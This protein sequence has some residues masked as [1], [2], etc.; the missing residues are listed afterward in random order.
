MPTLVCRLKGATQSWGIDGK[1]GIRDTENEPSKSGFFSLIGCAMGKGRNEFDYFADLRKCKMGV[2]I[3]LPGTKFVDFHTA[4]GVI[5]SDGGKNDDCVI[6]N[7]YYLSDAE[8]LVGLE[9]NKELLEAIESAIRDPKW[10]L[11]LGRKSN[12]PSLPICEPN[13]LSELTLISALQSYPWWWYKQNYWDNKPESVRVKIVHDSNIG[14][15]RNDVPIG[16]R[17]FISRRVAAFLWDVPQN[18]IKEW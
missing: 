3:D 13:G 1:S 4:K 14:S 12:I 7:R 2:R 6:S 15:L 8:F 5:R 11:F 18:L 10:T 16:N 17:K 9:G